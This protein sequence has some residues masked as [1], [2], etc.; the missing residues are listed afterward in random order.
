MIETTLY[1]T[2]TL[3][4]VM[5]DPTFPDAPSNYWLDLCFP[6]QVNFTEEF[7]DF[8]KLTS[9]RKLAPLV[10]PMAQGKPIYSEASKVSR[11][12]PAYVKPKDAVS[13]TRVIKRRPGNLTGAPQTP[14]QRFDA[15]VADIQREHRDAILRRHEWMAAQAILYGQVVLE[16]DAYPRDLVDFERSADHS[17]TLAGA[18]RWGETGVSILGNIETWRTM[19]RRAKFGGGTNRLTIG[20]AVWEVMRNDAEIR[21]MLKVDFRPSNNGLA[22]NLGIRE[23][24]DVEFV[25][26]LSGTLDVYVYSDY[27]EANGAVVP[28]MDERDVVLTGPNVQGIRAFGAILDKKAQF[29]AL[30]IF[31]K[32]WEDEDPPVT[33][34]MNQSA[35]LM[36]PVNPNNTFRARVIA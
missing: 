20:A 30:E 2:S 26:R 33:F 24:L 14:Q 25:G 35:P 32:M 3:L 9:Q 13:L 36:V 18:T 10:V 17:V 19:I 11:V 7:I 5:R 16:D 8:E 34:I 6:N 15:V 4:G 23:G 29:Q 22:L 21:E 28:F 31:P 1:T 27:Y 12:K